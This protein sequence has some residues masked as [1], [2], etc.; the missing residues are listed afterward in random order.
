M[1]PGIPWSTRLCS[2]PRPGFV[3]SVHKRVGDDFQIKIPIYDL[4]LFFEYLTYFMIN[5]SFGET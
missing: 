1:S 5:G 3:L 2:G 4:I